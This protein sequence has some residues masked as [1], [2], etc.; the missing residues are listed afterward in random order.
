MPTADEVRLPDEIFMSV[1]KKLSNGGDPF[2]IVL[3]QSLRRKRRVD[4]D[5]A[6]VAGATERREK[7]PFAASQLQDGLLTELMPLAK[8][9]DEFPS[10]AAERRRIRLR[11][12]VTVAEFLSGRVERQVKD[13]SAG[14]AMSEVQ[15]APTTRRRLALV[16]EHQCRE[17]RDVSL[18]KETRQLAGC[19]DRTRLL[20]AAH[21]KRDSGRYGHGMRSS[22]HGNGRQGRPGFGPGDVRRNLR[23][24]P[25]W[26]ASE[27]SRR[28][29][30]L[31][32]APGSS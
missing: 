19:A 31:P 14:T 9:F 1:V 13:E 12:L 7:V 17:D 6:V 4:T 25:G 27:A 28:V 11:I 29:V 3:R 8:S 5:S 24:Q 18:F 32:D 15:I 2:P 16:G 21:R 20:D 23:R 22:L 30:L 26:F 10:V